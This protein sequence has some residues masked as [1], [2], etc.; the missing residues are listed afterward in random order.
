MASQ[1]AATVAAAIMQGQ[2]PS[3]N[4]ASLQAA[5]NYFEQVSRSMI[6]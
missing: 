5:A 1:Q 6:L 4:P 3:A 2:S